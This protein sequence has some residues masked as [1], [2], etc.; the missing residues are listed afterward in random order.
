MVLPDVETVGF[1]TDL[2]ACATAETAGHK[3]IMADVSMVDLRPW[4]GRVIGFCAGPPCQSFSAAGRRKGKLD[5]PR[6]ER[7]IE[8]IRQAGRWLDYSREGWHDPRSPLVMEV[9]RYVLTLGP[10]WVVLEQVPQVLPLWER[11]ALVLNEHGYSTDT[12]VLKAEQYGVPQTRKRAILA[13][14][15]RVQ[16]MLPTPTHR[17]YRKGVAREAGDQSLLPWVTMR[18]ALGVDGSDWVLRSNYGTGGDPK[19]RGERGVDE[20]AP[21]VTEKV[22]RNKWVVSG[23][24][25]NAGP[26]AARE[27]RSVDEPSYTIRSAGSGSHPSGT[28]WVPEGRVSVEE[29]AVLQSFRPDFPW[30]GSRSSRYAQVGNAGPPLLMAAVLRQVAQ[31]A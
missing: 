28:Q 27:P 25:R 30:Q 13:A 18:D 5:M 6:I 19:A 3:R 21:T 12:G 31:S 29:A 8:R 7:H 1:E 24:A 14:S 11:V 17:H 16:A 4:V 2:D 20:P 10:E 9:L 23:H 15:R 22:G 26:A